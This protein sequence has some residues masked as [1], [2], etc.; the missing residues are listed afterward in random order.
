MVSSR[1]ADAVAAAVERLRLDYP[2]RTSAGVRATSR[3]TITSNSSGRPRVETLGP[4]DI[5]V[6][7]AGRDGLKMPFFALPKEDYLL[8][9]KTNVV[10]C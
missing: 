8:T 2:A 1:S 3:T 10:G 5:W 9:V 7:N 4:I 6:N